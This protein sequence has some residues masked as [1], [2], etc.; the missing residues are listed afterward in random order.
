[1]RSPAEFY[2]RARLGRFAT[3]AVVSC[4]TAAAVCGATA[5]NELGRPVFRDF[6]PGRSHISHL[7]QAVTQDADGFI[8]LANGANLACYDGATWKF[9][10]VPTDCAGIRKFAVTAE[11]TIYAGGAGVIGWIRR[12]GLDP[13]FVSLAGQLPPAERDFEDIYDVLAAGDAVYFATEKRILIWRDGHFAVVPCA[14]PPHSRGA[15][16]HRVGH[17]VYVTAP[18]QPLCRLADDRLEV[19]ADDPRLRENAIVAVEAGAADELVLLSAERGF[20]QLM[21]GRVTPRPAEANAWLAGKRIIGAQRLRDGSLV[22]AFSSVSGD[23]GMRFGADGGYVGPLDQFIGLYVKTIRAFLADREGG[24]WLGTETGLIRIEWPSAVTVF[25]AIN[26]LGQGAVADVARHEGTLYA[27][28]TEG[29]YRL[30]ASDAEGRVAHFERVLNQPVDALVSHP[31]GLLALGYTDLLVQTAAGFTTVAKVPPGGGSLRRSQR[32][33]DRVWITTTHGVRSVRHTPQGWRDEGPA[34]DAAEMAREPA[35]EPA[36]AQSGLPHLVRASAGPVSRM[37]EE[38]APGGHALWICGAKGLVR[39]DLAKGF[40]AP[41]PFATMLVAT[42][43]RDGDRL[44]AGRTTLKFDFVA[45]RHQVADAVSYQTRLGGDEEDWSVWSATRTRTFANL[46]AG[47]Y[48]FEVRARDADGQLAAPASLGF[49]ILPPWWRT[50]WAFLGYAA[51]GAGVLAG[52]VRFRTRALHRRADQ[53][54]AIIAERTAELAHKNTEL[55]RLNQLELD[56]K[57]SA[58]LAEEKARLETLRYQLNPHFLF[59]TLASISSALGAERS[60][61]RTMVERLAD[62]CRLTLHR[63]NDSDWTTL[64]GELKLLRA[65]LEIEQSRWGELLDVE[66]ASAAGLENERLPH[67]LLL[68]LVENALKYGRATSPDRVGLRLAARRDGAGALVLEVANTGEWIEPA[69]EKTVSSFGIGLENLR[70]RLARH[71]AR[72]HS[73]EIAHGDGWVTV[74]LRILPPPG[75]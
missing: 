56:E 10:A 18:G 7:C 19:V 42:G 17:A 27:A 51:A 4:A 14:T 70:E 47:D 59:N 69:A 20:F 26:G 55:V 43:V 68:P 41:A 24:L 75:V 62:F 49:S 13:E 32:D 23:G 6:P 22:V 31:D 60:P 21:A 38:T 58:R 72:A 46:P 29:V 5:P 45:L 66:I 35:E 16:L 33:P 61:A 48:R 30:E 12:K 1:M 25:D 74:T 53:L 34:R 57:I 9:F 37:R 64:G 71:Y 11:G 36:R 63:P 52:L 54:E 39:V 28:T 40:P 8:Y 3:C 50:G 15:R 44:P 65:Y 73:L 67:F 2:S